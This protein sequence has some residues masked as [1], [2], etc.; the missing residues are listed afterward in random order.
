MFEKTTA[1]K[2]YP[3]PQQVWVCLSTERRAAVIRLMAQLAFNVIEAQSVAFS[4]EKY[5]VTH[6]QPEDSPRPS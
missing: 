3:L 6:Q 4:Q 1:T 2:G 5:H